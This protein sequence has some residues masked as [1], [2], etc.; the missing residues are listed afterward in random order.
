MFFLTA[1][2]GVGAAGTAGRRGGVPHGG[3]GGEAGGVA[4][5]LCAVVDTGIHD[6]RNTCYF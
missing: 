1:V 2:G 3:A 5:R 6:F 4:M